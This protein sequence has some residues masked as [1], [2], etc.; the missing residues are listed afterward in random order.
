M[1]RKEHRNYNSAYI[2]SKN[3]EEANNEKMSSSL[4]RKRFQI[5]DFKKP[6]QKQQKNKREIGTIYLPP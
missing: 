4:A 1:C 2:F 6:Q 3:T 5:D